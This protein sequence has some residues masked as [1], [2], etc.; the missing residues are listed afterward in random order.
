MTTWNTPPT[1]PATGRHAAPRFTP[2][3]PISL[4]LRRYS[5]QADGRWLGGPD[6]LGITGL[7]ARQLDEKNKLLDTRRQA[8]FDV[9]EQAEAAAR[10]A[11]ML[12]KDIAAIPDAAYQT[13]QPKDK[14]LLFRSEQASSQFLSACRLIPEDILLVVPEKGAGENQTEW[15]LRGAT[16]A[17]PSHWQLAEK[18]GKTLAELHSPVPEFRRRLAG[19]VNRFFDAMQPAHISWRQN[20]SMQT[21]D[22]LFAPNRESIHPE[23]LTR[24]QAGSHIFIRIETQHFYKLPISGAVIFAI[25][26]SLAPLSF[27][28]DNPAPIAALASQ[29]D[30]LSENM[31]E[32]K[33]IDK[34][35]PAL[36]HWLDSHAD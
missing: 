29:I 6:P 15:R 9:H 5:N 2:A 25:R 13:D 27:W 33:A 35:R 12:I 31:Q 19:P 24:Q 22:R 3:P 26:T 17:F 7:R 10:E 11:A 36:H 30:Q 28:N 1:L 23:K 21:D 32:Y 20:W 8:V 18:M 34:L 16:L 14:A 4:G